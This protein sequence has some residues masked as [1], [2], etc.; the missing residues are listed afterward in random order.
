MFEPNSIWD[1]LSGEVLAAV[2]MLLEA[3]SGGKK[4]GPSPLGSVWLGHQPADGRV[5][6]PFPI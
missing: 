2:G 5:S 6:A 3:E 1:F 4:A